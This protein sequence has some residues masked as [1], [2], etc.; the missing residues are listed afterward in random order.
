MTDRAGARPYRGSGTE[1][2]TPNGE[3]QTK[4]GRRQPALP[5]SSTRLRRLP[6]RC[7][8]ADLP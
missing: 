6:V 1:R 3:R 5:T 7:V 2:R 4:K 8:P